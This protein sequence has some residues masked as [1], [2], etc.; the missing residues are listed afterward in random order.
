MR[1]IERRPQ[2]LAIGWIARRPA[3]QPLRLAVRDAAVFGIEGAR[4]GRQ[5]GVVQR[6]QRRQR[7]A[8]QRAAPFADAVAMHGFVVGEVVGAR[9]PRSEERRVGEE[10]VSTCRSRWSPYHLK[11][12]KTITSNK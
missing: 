9:R 7:G 1:S 2:S 4:G 11:T 3:Q 10:C 8:E 12:T 5:A 6:L